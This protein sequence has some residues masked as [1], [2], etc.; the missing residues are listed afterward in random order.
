MER[1]TFLM[2]DDFGYARNSTDQMHDSP[3]GVLRL[4]Y[5]IQAKF[6]NRESKAQRM[7]T[8]FRL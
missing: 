3:A 2:L 5:G 6:Y 7:N 8:R 1:L 4:Y